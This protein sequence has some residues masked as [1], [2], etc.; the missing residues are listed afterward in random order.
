MELPFV[1]FFIVAY[2]QEKYIADAINGAFAQDYPN[3]EI[4][5]SDDCSTDN[6][7]QI[8]QEM[9]SNY[10]GDK[11]VRLNRND[12]NIGPREHFNK[13]LY[14]LAKGDI[15]V[16]SAG[17]DVSLPER[18][19]VSVDFFEKYPEVVSLSFASQTVNEQLQ[20]YA[21]EV[22]F[23][24]SKGF[25]TIITLEDYVLY[26]F[27]IFSGDSRVIRR[28]V[29]NS[30]PPLQ[31]S[32]S[33]DIFIFLR[34]LYLGPIAYLRQPLVLYRQHEGSVKS[35][36][37]SEKHFH[38]TTE[39]QMLSDLDYAISHHYLEEEQRSCIMK[40]ISWVLQILKN[41]TTLKKKTHHSLLYCILRA[42]KK[43]CIRYFKKSEE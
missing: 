4:I 33:E 12:C 3:M 6:T 22:Q 19:R 27:F 16:F 41:Q 1:T 2:N 10:K 9:A 24:L 11:N 14:Q 40:R 36:K 42:I 29:V 20:P 13:I 5:I 23:S 25:N 35:R 26:D 15:I 7:W 34:S 17:D 28:R 21:E 38:E 32:Y 30:F 8:I 43:E 39:K 31:Y 18:T 37:V